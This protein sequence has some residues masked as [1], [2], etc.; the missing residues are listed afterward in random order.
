MK[1]ILKKKARKTYSLRLE[2][3][4]IEQARDLGLDINTIIEL[5]L[6]KALKSALNE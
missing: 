6:V 1:P 4:L 3:G 2:P 5:A